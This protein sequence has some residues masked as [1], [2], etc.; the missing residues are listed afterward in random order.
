MWLTAGGADAD[1]LAVAAAAELLRGRRQAPD[2]LR[3][4]RVYVAGVTREVSH[5][6]LRALL[7]DVTGVEVHSCLNVDHCGAALEFTLVVDAA[8]AFRAALRTS[9]AASVLHI[10]SEIDPASPAL[11]GHARSRQLGG[12]RA[13]E[14]SEAYYCSRLLLKLPQKQKPT[15][16]P[17]HVRASL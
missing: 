2:L 15:A 17:P 16:L 7:A 3:L 5:H 13:A 6:S 4:E 10:L 9:R 1:D 14:V 12:A 11:L 8:D